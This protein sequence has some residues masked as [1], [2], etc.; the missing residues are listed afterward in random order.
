MA[1]EPNVDDMADKSL[2]PPRVS[3][4][5]RLR[6][7]SRSPHPYHR[8]GPNLSDSSDSAQ[9]RGQDGGIKGASTCTAGDLD[10]YGED[11][12]ASERV[13]RHPQ[14]PSPKNSSDS[15]TDADDESGGFLKILPAP[16][17]R[18]RKGLRGIGPDES[19]SPLP[20]PSTLDVDL[21]KLLV[22]DSRNA[23][24]KPRPQDETVGETKRA[25]DKNTRK[26]IAEI[27]RRISETGLLGC[28][29]YTV[30][31]GEG[32]APALKKWRSG[33]YRAPL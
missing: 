3:S 19:V 10:T 15:G 20:T 17:T 2:L 24:G 29:G 4:S 30:Y 8:R 21:R 23:V 33:E 7:P 5:N 11:Q 27:L 28:V 12:T 18:V 26:K 14:A 31:C 32:V 13:P 25:R 16:S 1:C 22:Q 6:N 9:D